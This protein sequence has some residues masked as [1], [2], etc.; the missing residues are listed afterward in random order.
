[1]SQFVD[2]SNYRIFEMYYDKTLCLVL[3]STGQRNIGL[4]IAYVR[5]YQFN[6][7]YKNG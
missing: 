6:R 3:V 1:M 4:G 5:S 7:E 2:L